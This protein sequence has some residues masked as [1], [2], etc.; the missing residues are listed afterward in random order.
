LLTIGLLM[1]AILALGV[2]AM[3]GAMVVAQLNQGMAAAV[4]QSGTLRMQAYRIAAELVPPERVATA[5]MPAEPSAAAPTP[6]APA[7]IDR[8]D[9]NQ[10]PR[11]E[12]L[13]QVQQLADE[14][15]ARLTSPRLVAAIPSAAG[16]PLRR[17]YQQ[18]SQQWREV[19]RPALTAETVATGGLAYRAQ[20]DDFVA[21]IHHLVHALE[22]R[23]ERRID[24]LAGMQAAAL[25]LT[26]VAVVVTLLLLQRRLVRP[27][28][29][30]LHCA[31]RVR[32]GDFSVR[33]RFL[34]DDELGRLGAAMNLMTKGLWDIYNELEER[35]ADKTR[36]LARSNQSLQLL[37]RTSRT[38]NDATLSDPT[39]RK[40]LIDLER[41]LKLASVTLCLRERGGPQGDPA[42]AQPQQLQLSASSGLCI[43]SHQPLH[44]A[45][46]LAQPDPAGHPCTHCR[47]AEHPP[48][49]A[50]I[51]VPVADQDRRYGTLRLL[52][53]D[54]APLQPWQEPLLEA[55]ATQLATA[56][57]LQGRIRES[58]RLVLHEERSILAREL[59]DSLAQSLSYLK[60][61]ALRL[62]AALKAPAAAEAATPEAILAEM[63]DGISSAY[64]QLRELLNTFR[65]KIDGQ[66]LGAALT[67]TLD[68]FRARNDLVILLDDQLPP[69]L[70]SANEEVHVLQI[71]REALVN[72]A[73]HARARQVEVRLRMQA[74]ASADA[75]RAGQSAGDSDRQEHF[76]TV[77]V[78]VCDDGIGL[79]TTDAKR[80]HY[81]LGIMRERA[82]SLGGTLQIDS[83]PKQGT[84]VSLCFRSRMMTPMRT[85]L[86]AEQQAPSDAILSVSR[87]ST[88]KPFAGPSAQA[89]FDSGAEAGPRRRET[90]SQAVGPPLVQASESSR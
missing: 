60:I 47:A 49:G 44:A 46:D 12:H 90:A 72:T 34:G 14:L 38:L 23:A 16:D 89:A 28:E 69:G 77:L 82:R 51:V 75:P 76:S 56:L 42:D 85:P 18:V 35:V 78:E 9:R 15:E 68:E 65:L 53:R 32:Q 1:A 70:L 50:T 20:V 83:A 25:G 3:V 63:R 64:R 30:L 74:D 33:T 8:T 58:R 41:E 81:G 80:G 84:K 31:D 55:L 7:P 79:A 48:D 4:N 19:M 61:Q 39:L 43:S 54:G 36:D 86:Q 17:A 11:A 2:T 26:L 40:V 88:D 13:T 29:A 24:W 5:P 73:R 71:I 37:Y 52:C 27:F 6:T 62:D 45:A 22:E 57:N 10:P 67:R 66:G 21:Q 59:H 87:Q